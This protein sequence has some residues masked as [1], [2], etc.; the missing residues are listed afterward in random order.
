MD[1]T[2]NQE[3]LKRVS[4]GDN[5]AESELMERNLG[6][7]RSIALRFRDRGVEYEDLVQI[8]SIGM[9]KAIKSFDISKG[10]AF[11]TY[12]VPLIIGEI[13][14]FI[15]DDGLIKV[16]RKYKEICMDVARTQKELSSHL[17]REP[18]INEIAQSMGVDVYIVTEAMEACAPC[19]SIY[20]TVN[21]ADGG[22]MLVMDTLIG[23]DDSAFVDRASIKMAV[24]GLGEKARR[25]IAY[26]Y[27]MDETQ[28]HVAKRLG[29]SQVQVS[30]IEK[31]ALKVLRDEYAR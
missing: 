3:L 12:A 31:K 2:T 6:L 4:S 25:V 18:T 14:R 13:R 9:F 23:A 28:S 29:I 8:G 7:V 30:R 17:L 26:R 20:R 15:R 1:F 5:L 19:D 16:S 21:D 10:T 22:E 24:E 27:F 11:S